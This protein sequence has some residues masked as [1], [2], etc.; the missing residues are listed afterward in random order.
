MKQVIIFSLLLIMLLSSFEALAG[1]KHCQS[2]RKK[3]D[4][5]Q[6]QQR[7]ANSNKRSKSLATQEAKA[8]NNWWQCEN[9]KLKSKTKKKQRV[10]LK[11]TDQKK[12]IS[13]G[14]A[15]NKKIAPLK[16]L[17]PF[18]SNSPVVVRSKYQGEKLQAWLKFYQVNKGCRQPKSMSQFS[19]CVEDKRRQ[20]TEFEKSY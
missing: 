12:I 15:N 18:A 7:Q 8:R 10:K 20:Q 16:A 17:V 19:A 9:G 13:V 14:G 6:A 11:H 3:L 1:K 4:S 2:Y 5:I